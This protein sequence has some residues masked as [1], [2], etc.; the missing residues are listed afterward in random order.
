MHDAEIY[1]LIAAVVR[2]NVTGPPTPEQ[3]MYV[4]NLCIEIIEALQLAGFEIRRR[5][6]PAAR[7]DA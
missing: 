4:D 5:K 2:T 1:E 3:D 7:S 6:Q